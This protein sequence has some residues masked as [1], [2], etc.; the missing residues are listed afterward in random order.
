MNKETNR[1]CANITIYVNMKRTPE[2]LC[3]LKWQ[4]HNEQTNGRVVGY[5]FGVVLEID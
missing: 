2:F 3:A 1:Q 4:E 5:I